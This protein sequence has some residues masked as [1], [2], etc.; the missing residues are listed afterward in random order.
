MS[1]SKVFIINALENIGSSKEG[2][3]NKK[4]KESIIKALGN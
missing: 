4:L 1:S 3:K 2:R